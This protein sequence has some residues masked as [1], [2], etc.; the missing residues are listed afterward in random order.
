MSPGY[1]QEVIL[2]N[3]NIYAYQKLEHLLLKGSLGKFIHF[4]VLKP[5]FSLGGDMGTPLLAALGSER[6][7]TTPRGLCQGG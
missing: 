1:Y 4:K 5:T 3:E 6:D 7:H 2:K